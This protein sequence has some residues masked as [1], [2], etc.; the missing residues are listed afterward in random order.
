[1]QNIEKLINQ[2]K[3]KRIFDMAKKAG[4]IGINKG[5]RVY[6][7]GGVVRDLLL[8][9]EI[10]DLDLM[11]EGDGISF[12]KDLANHIGVRKIVPFKKFGTA[13]I[14]HRNFQIEVASSRSELYDNDSRSPT[15]VIFTSLEEDLKRR[16]FTINA[17]A[18]ISRI[19]RTEPI[20]SIFFNE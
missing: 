18:I 11:V 16:D 17:M 5:L 8:G 14:P 2:D 6:I 7:V 12:A 20:K 1:M 10:Q 15:K 3:Y 19:N 9:R 4:A 13:L